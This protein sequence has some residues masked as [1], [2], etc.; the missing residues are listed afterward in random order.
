MPQEHTRKSIARTAADDKTGK[1]KWAVFT[2]VKDAY[3]VFT[4]QGLQEGALLAFQT[5]RSFAE[6]ACLSFEFSS[7]NYFTQA[8]IGHLTIGIGRTTDAETGQPSL[9][10]KGIVI[11]NVS[12]YGCNGECT[13]TDYTNTVAI[14]SYWATG[15][16]VHGQ[17]SQ[18]P[19][20]LQDDL[21]YRV[22][23]RVLPPCQRI[24]YTLWSRGRH[25]KWKTLHHADVHDK[26]FGNS[27]NA[28]GWWIGEVFSQHA[29]LVN[30][31][32]IKWR[33]DGVEEASTP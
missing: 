5:G 7:P 17:D 26:D 19:L 24:Q 25:G 30:F 18:S 31:R 29:W 16:C 3:H 4:P 15:N 21:T 14:E 2:H 32:S 27:D 8:N 11:G 12:A 22:E 10:G 13:Q 9:Q 1:M 23:V 6:E 28:A 20:E 33:F